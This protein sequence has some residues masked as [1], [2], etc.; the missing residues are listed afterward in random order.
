MWLADT[1]I[2]RPVFATMFILA[3]VILGLVSYPEIGVDLFPKIEFPIVNITTRLNG[4][5]PE[6]MD[7]DVTDKIE[8]SV[9]TINGVKTITSTSAEGVSTISIEFVLERDIDM[10]VQDVREKVSLIRSKL[11]TDILE[12]IIQKVDPD[13][14]PVYYIALTGRKTIRDLSTYADEVLKDQLQ[15][16]NG[17]GALR[18]IGLRLRQVR[19]WLDADKLRAF[20][21]TPN[22]VMT[23]LSRENVEIPGGRIEAATKEYT[24][25]VK[26]EFPSVQEFNDLIVSWYRGVPVRIRD[27]GRAED[28]MEEQ[29][30]IVRFNGLPAVAVGIQ[31]QSGTNTVEVIDRV[32]TEIEKIRKT[33]P[34]GMVIHAAFDQ[35][36]FINRSIREVQN[37]LIIGGILAVIAVFLFLRNVRTTLI[38]AVALP[39]SVIATFTLIRAF[40]F[41]FNNMTMLALSL[42]VGILID[43]AIIV[44]ENIHRNIEIGMDPREAASFATSEIG[45]A[46]MATTL[47]IVAIFLPVAFMKGIIGRFFMSFALTVVFAV[48]VS[49]LVS[50]TLTPML[51]A[52]FLRRRQH[53]NDEEAQKSGQGRIRM[54]IRRAGDF[55]EAYYR[56]TETWYRKLLVLGLRYRLSVLTGAL[57]IFV[58]SMYMTK[59]MGKEFVPPED[60]SNFIIRLEAPIDYSVAESDRLFQQAE[61]IVRNTPEVV[62]V[63]YAQGLGTAGTGQVNK[64]RMTVG[65]K[66]KSER[67]RSQE[68]I[69]AELRRRINQIPGLKG[70]A[71]DISL[72]GGGVRNVPIQYVVR[73]TDL[74]YLTDYMKQIVA[75]FAK[76]PGVVD[77]DTSLE[78]GKPELRVTIDRDKAADLGVSVADIAAAINVLISGE[79]DV[80][81][82]KDEAKGRRY[83]VRVRL[84]P[85]DRMNPGD[86]GKIYIRAR[87]GRLVE[88]ANVVQIREGGAPSTIYRVDRQRAMIMYASLEK[89]PLG[90]AMD[91]L[92]AIA[93]GILP[94]DYSAKYKGAADTMKESFGFLIFALLLGVLMAYMVL[95]AQ[96]ESFLQPVIVLLSMPLSFIG[97]F[98]ALVLTGKTISIFSMI[99]LILLMGLVK[100]NA[101]L[102]VD[103]TNTLRERGMSRREAILE[104]GP[105]RLRPILMTTFAM[106][107]GML[108]VAAG[109]GDGAETRSPM[110]VAVIGGL[111]TSL[112]LTLVV[113]PAAYDLFDEWQEKIKSRRRKKP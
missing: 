95:A 105:V 18:F 62:R 78:A 111:I 35:S 68:E 4:A 76:L 19:I 28:G 86:I 60:Q 112:F 92:N 72:I 15:R 74:S 20:Q 24:V 75:R 36:T 52:Y 69:K 59:F 11:P 70:T 99:G 10:A 31:K 97:A 108:P 12:P 82:F 64:G 27:V 23:A 3:L 16:I 5:S 45:L 109:L 87:D 63:M 44:I 51:A 6:I 58:L 14:N 47:A 94:L 55:L 34:P 46:V 77:V 7:I 104:A 25:K 80:T 66:K 65:L 54:K 38:S 53:G 79:V 81:K 100:K 89:K 49:L 101:I 26:G 61:E 91:E 93:A 9:N 90:Q 48:M 41:T 30:S 2:K 17:V 85:Q 102:L 32:K 83:D 57:I 1:S 13:A 106:I 21:V 37:H 50:F 43:D 113:V 73:G 107:F 22:D 103:Y 96:F 8:E 71:E 98:G 56:K 110:G 88:L 42:S 84:N 40:D 39:I 29:R 67:K 33:L